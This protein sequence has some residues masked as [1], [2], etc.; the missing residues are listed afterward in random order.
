MGR[1]SGKCCFVFLCSAEVNEWVRYGDSCVDIEVV[2][3]GLC[4][5]LVFSVCVAVCVE[6]V[7]PC[8]GVGSCVGFSYGR[9]LVGCYLGRLW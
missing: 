1:C 7:G 4:A 8:R 3:W 5:Y 9:R 6:V 2:L